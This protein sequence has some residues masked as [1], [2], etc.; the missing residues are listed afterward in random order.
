MKALIKAIGRLR[1]R[2][3]PVPYAASFFSGHQ[4]GSAR[5]AAVIVP[6]VL[7]TY[8]VASV[9]DVGCG[10]G[11][12]LAEFERLGVTDYLGMDGDYVPRGLLR[13]PVDPFR[14]ADLSRL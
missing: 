12:W 8:E 4:D 9:I 2:A 11:T 6:L 3:A 7:Q 14:A 13:I 5:S 1:A 10:V